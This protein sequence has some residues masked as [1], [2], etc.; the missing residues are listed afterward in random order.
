[1]R[2]GVALAVVVLDLQLIHQR[3]LLAGEDPDGELRSRA[4]E[5]HVECPPGLRLGRALPAAQIPP[6]RPP[7]HYH[8]EVEPFRAGNREQLH[9]WR[10]H[11]DSQLAWPQQP[12][13]YPR[14]AE[15]RLERFE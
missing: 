10:L 13:R 12:A 7:E 2:L 5:R 15:R 11:L 8:R 1:R 6:V 14:R 9:L 4:R 3:V